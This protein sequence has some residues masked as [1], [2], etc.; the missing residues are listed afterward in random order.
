LHNI[1]IIALSGKIG[2]RFFF[3]VS[4]IRFLA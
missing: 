4:D 3:S 1:K 2:K